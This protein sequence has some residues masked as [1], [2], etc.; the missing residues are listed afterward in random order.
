MYQYRYSFLFLSQQSLLILLAVSHCS[1]IHGNAAP[2]INSSSTLAAR[3]PAPLYEPQQAKRFPRV[4]F[5]PKVSCCLFR[6]Y[7]LPLVKALDVD[8]SSSQI[9]MWQDFENP[10]K[11]RKV[12][13]VDAR[14]AAER[15]S[16]S[17]DTSTMILAR[18]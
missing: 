18:L 6:L 1:P 14:N 10:P 2:R 5:F 9:H 15:C 7:V 17:A 3:S 16:S 13:K 11:G 4:V 12:S 8:A